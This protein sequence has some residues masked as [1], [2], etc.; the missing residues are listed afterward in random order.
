MLAP[1][2]PKNFYSGGCAS[3]LN[4]FYEVLYL[5]THLYNHF[6]QRGYFFLLHYYS[7]E[8]L[9]PDFQNGADHWRE[10][11]MSLNCRVSGGFSV[12][13]TQG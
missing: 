9:G 2:I 7:F 13:A 1:D 5:N 10:V 4:G 12:P 11:R 8:T 6:V 3:L